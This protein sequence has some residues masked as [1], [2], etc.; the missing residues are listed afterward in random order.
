MLEFDGPPTPGAN[1]DHTAFGLLD[2]K[3]S[4]LDRTIL[5]AAP[6]GQRTA[7]T[8]TSTPNYE[9]QPHE[10]GS[11]VDGFGEPEIVDSN[12]FLYNGS[13][14]D[15]PSRW[16]GY[17]EA[18]WLTRESDAPRPYSF[19]AILNDFD[20]ELGARVE[21]GRKY[22]CL[23]GVEFVY[24]GLQQWNEVTTAI[25]PAG[26]L[27]TTLIPQLGVNLS[28]FNG[29]NAHRLSYSTGL[30]NFE[31]NRVWYGWDVI[32]TM[33]GV[34]YLNIDEQFNFDSID[35]NGDV[36][37]L[38][39]AA[40]NNLYGF[41]IGGEMDYPSSQRLTVSGSAKVGAFLN[42]IDESA[43]L[44]NAGLVQFA[45]SNREYGFSAL[46]EFGIHASYRV[47]PRLAVRAGYE[48]WYIYGLGLAPAQS[49][50]NATPLTG[51][52]TD[53]DS[54]VLYHGGTVGAELT[55]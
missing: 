6:E 46:G 43:A 47:T 21:F 12:E 36:G 30:H 49:D 7:F 50:G 51:I 23:D 8:S 34:R 18:F 48:F 45:N 54:D 9:D 13:C 41:Q 16:H 39:L 19:N 55:W 44:V 37:R 32:S 38:G 53:E 24:A 20:Y 28:A 26:A 31:A 40:E 5:A 35:F 27:N 2:G 14:G 22:D 52:N 10:A 42:A 33:I 25:G 11:V 17:A 15:C 4:P 29:A 3:T 1:P